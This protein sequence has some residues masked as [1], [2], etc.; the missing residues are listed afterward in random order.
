MSLETNKQTIDHKKKRE[1]GT[2]SAKNL[3]PIILIL[4]LQAL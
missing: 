3:Q 4:Y 1:I 2:T